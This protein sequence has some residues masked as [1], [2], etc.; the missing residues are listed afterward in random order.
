MDSGGVDRDYEGGISVVT[1]PHIERDGFTD[2]ISICISDS[3][4][5]V[6]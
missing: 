3:T 2:F 6:Y 5:F 4:C 1:T